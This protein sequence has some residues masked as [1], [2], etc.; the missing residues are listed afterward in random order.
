MHLTAEGLLVT[1]SLSK[2]IITDLW[3]YRTFG[4]EFSYD[5]LI[6]G[7]VDSLQQRYEVRGDFFLQA[8]TLL[9]VN[10]QLCSLAL[11]PEVHRDIEAHEER[12]QIIQDLGLGSGPPVEWVIGVAWL[13][14]A[15]FGVA[16]LG[17]EQAH[18]YKFRWSG[19]KDS[20][21]PKLLWFTCRIGCKLM[22]ELLFVTVFVSLIQALDCR[23]IASEYRLDADPT[24]ICWRGFHLFQAVMSGVVTLFYAYLSLRVLRVGGDI[25]HIFVDWTRPWDWSS[26]RVGVAT[27]QMRRMHPLSKRPTLDHDGDGD[28][29]AE[30]L[31]RFEESTTCGVMESPRFFDISM[32]LGKALISFFTVLFSKT[33]VLVAVVTV[34]V[35][36]AIA[37]SAVW[38]R[39]YYDERVNRVLNGTSL[40]VVWVH[41]VAL[42]GTCNSDALNTASVVCFAAILVVVGVAGFHFDASWAGGS[43][44]Q[45]HPETDENDGGGTERT[46]LAGGAETPS[47]F[48][49]PV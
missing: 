21:G 12:I 34:L 47:A 29:D 8:G 24:V 48:V 4:V 39:P 15:L 32:L 41:I 40:G 30:E 37:V 45:V 16:V 3:W 22:S 13:A 31:K 20:K 7:C 49:A 9:V 6:T 28:I 25:E 1:S 36:A 38:S 11:R 10:L 17:A 44:V 18:N 19:E 2:V 23:Q 43:Q 42:I 27:R 14:V 26:D 5:P 33:P 35:T 46:E